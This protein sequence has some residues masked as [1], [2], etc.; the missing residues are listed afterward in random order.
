MKRD[1]DQ[2]DKDLDREEIVDWV[3]LIVG[4]VMA[5]AA[6]SPFVARLF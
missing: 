2:T 5:I 3:V 6:L 4:A 1:K